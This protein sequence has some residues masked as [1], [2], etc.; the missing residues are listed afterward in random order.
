MTFNISHFARTLQTALAQL[1]VGVHIMP[2]LVVTADNTIHHSASYPSHII[3]PIAPL[4]RS[5]SER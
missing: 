5:R 4:R 2:P 3:L 1:D